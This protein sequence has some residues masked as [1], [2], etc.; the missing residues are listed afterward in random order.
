[1][2]VVDK[3]E[4]AKKYYEKMIKIGDKDSIEYA[5]KMLEKL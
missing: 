2:V 5:R 3:K 1:V 4:M